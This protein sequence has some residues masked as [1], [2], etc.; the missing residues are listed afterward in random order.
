MN[1]ILEYYVMRNEDGVT[2]WL[3]DDEFL[4]KGRLETK[5]TWT[6]DLHQSSAFTSARQAHDCAKR[7]LNDDQIFYVM[8]CMGS[9]TDEED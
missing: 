1:D 2:M 4:A 6:P 5:A 3:N 7:Q 9:E 8:G